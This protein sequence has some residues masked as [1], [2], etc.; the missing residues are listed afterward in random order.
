M[1]VSKSKRIFYLDALRAVA[2]LTVIA[3][4]VYAVTRVQ[5]MADFATGPS[6]RWLFSQFTGNNLRIGVDLFLM[7]AGALSL[8]REW[9]IKEFNIAL[10]LWSFHVNISWI[11]TLLVLLDDIGNLFDNAYFQ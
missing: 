5:V 2:I 1:A 4:H 3:V 7:L 6:L 10:F 8:G 9:S 11:L